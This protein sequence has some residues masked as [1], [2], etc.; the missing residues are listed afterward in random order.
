MT[1][2]SGQVGC[3]TIKGL[4]KQDIFN[5]IAAKHE[6]L[7]IKDLS[8]LSNFINRNLIHAI[9]NCAA[10]TAVDKAESEP[11]SCWQVNSGGTRNLA[12]ICAQHQI[13][14]IH[15]STDY[16]YHNT[17]RRPL[18]ETDPCSP[19]NEY[20]KSKL[21]GDQK[22]LFH[23]PRTII[24]RTSWVYAAEGSNFLNTIIGHCKTKPEL[25]IVND[26]LGAPTLA[27]DL[28]ID[29]IEILKQVLPSKDDFNWY[30]IY[31]CANK[32]AISW[33]EF[34]HY[35]IEKL[36]LPC[37][38]NP[39]PTT[40]FPRPAARPSYSVLNLEKIQNRFGIKIR[41]WQVALEECLASKVYEK[42]I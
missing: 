19:K 20:G 40:E 15:F 42:G 9:V 16:V 22:A 31:N 26:Q 39:V 41:D 32:G 21:D 25:N 13:P 6:E 35:F 29:V 18:V 27:E 12:L 17:V 4:A 23:N 5:G 11:E 3:A 36:D 38:V 24:L 8:S 1:G 34:A 37:K 28:A 33:Y 7:D 2:A 14:L 10:Y 30:G